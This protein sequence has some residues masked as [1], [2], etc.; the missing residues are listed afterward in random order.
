[1]ACNRDVNETRKRAYEAVGEASEQGA[2]IVCLP[3]LFRSEYFCRERNHGHFSQAE[4]IPGPGT[5][6]LCSLA[7]TLGVIIIA[8]LFERRASGIFHNSAVVIDSNGLKGLYRKA[9]I[10]DEPLYR[11]KFY[12]TPGGL[13]FP[14]FDTSAGRIAVQICWDQW[15]PEAAR[16]AAMGGA[17]VLFY[18]SA[19]GWAAHEDESTRTADLEAWCTIQR[20]HSIANGM[21]VAALNRVGTEGPPEES[22]EFWGNS[23]VSNP[24]GEVISEPSRNYEKVIIAEIDPDAC[25]KA[26]REWPFFRDRRPDMYG[27]LN[28]T[29]DD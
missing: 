24:F 17:S 25:E 11:E 4:P 7:A 14:V 27:M 18:P 15:F 2:E 12:F 26:R 5:D 28:R 3:E 8:G 22:L 20:S 13:G 1:M 19:I 21:Y 16:A 10:P 23:F 9:H 6:E 29:W